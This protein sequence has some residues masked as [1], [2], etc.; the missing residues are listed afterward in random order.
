MPTPIHQHLA[1]AGALAAWEPLDDNALVTCKIRSH[2]VWET[3]LY[4]FVRKKD[5]WLIDTNP[6][7]LRR[8][9]WE[10]VVDWFCRMRPIEIELLTTV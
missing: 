9:S 5:G 3:R 7:F 2:D 8:V 10:E 1:D 4:E 6:G